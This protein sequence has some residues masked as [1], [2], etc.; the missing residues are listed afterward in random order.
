[1]E[2]SKKKSTPKKE[3]TKL[4]MQELEN[5]AQNLF[6]ENRNLKEAMVSKRLDYLFRILECGGYFKEEILD[7][8]SE[9]IAESLFGKETTKE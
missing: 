1:M 6:V 9:E 5:F 2:E 7:K 8:V 4:T 3:G